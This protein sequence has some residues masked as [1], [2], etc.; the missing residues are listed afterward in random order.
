VRKEKLVLLDEMKGQ[1][2]QSGSFVIAEY[3]KMTGSC[4]Y[5]FRREL[6]KFGGY[7]EVVGKSMLVQAA[8]Q[9]G[10]EIDG[11]QLAGH[12]GLVLGVKD[13]AAVSKTVLKFSEEHDNVLRLVGG[14]L[15]GQTISAEDANR[16]A[17]LPSRDQMRAEL[18]GLLCAAP[19]G[20]VTTMSSLLGSVV[21]CL[22]GRIRK[23]SEPS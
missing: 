16:I 12:I 8:R 19:T 11:K 3:S 5:E 1:I 18:I 17:T 15:E 21:Q 22:D 6:A 10:I 7:F 14:Y 20:V 4:T 23:E 13:A 2:Q 9:L